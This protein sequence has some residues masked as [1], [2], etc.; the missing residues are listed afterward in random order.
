MC[1]ML[2]YSRLDEMREAARRA[3]KEVYIE[4]FQAMFA[5]RV[6]S[7]RLKQRRSMMVVSQLA[8]LH[9]TAVFEYERRHRKPSLESAL[10]LADYFDVSLDFLV[11][12]EGEGGAE[13]EF[14]KKA[15]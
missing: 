12:R 4:D 8:G 3:E 10:K 15:G 13:D 1:S 2:S 11:G 6:R 7:L 14:A 5:Q 9:D